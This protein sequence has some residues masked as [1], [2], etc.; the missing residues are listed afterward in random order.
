MMGYVPFF[1]LCSVILDGVVLHF[2][3]TLTRHDI[4]ADDGTIARVVHAL[5]AYALATYIVGF[6]LTILSAL[7]ETASALYPALCA[8][9]SFSRVRALVMILAAITRTSA[10]SV[11]TSPPFT[12]ALQVSEADHDVGHRVVPLAW[13]S[14]VIQ[15]YVAFVLVGR[16]VRREERE[17]VRLY[18]HEGPTKPADPSTFTLEDDKQAHLV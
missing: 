15:V 3:N 10:Y 5:F 8:R 1:I 16:S 17:S 12:I 6:V 13:T 4:A 9:D 7:A 18:V 11:V 2:T 14:L